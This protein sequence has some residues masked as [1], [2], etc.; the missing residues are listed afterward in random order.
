MDVK[1][2]ENTISENLLPNGSINNSSDQSFN[3]T[4]FR[5]KFD[6]SYTQNISPTSTIKFTL[7]GNTANSNN[8]NTSST[9]NRRSDSTLINNGE[10]S[11]NNNGD[12]KGFNISG[13]WNKKL[14]VKGRAISVSVNESVNE[15]DNGGFLMSTNRFYDTMNHLDSVADVDQKKTSNLRQSILNTSA[16]YR[17]P[18]SKFFSTVLSYGYSILNSSSER[19]SF[20]RSASGI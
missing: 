16:T 11:L 18:L 13:L 10:R 1:G 17:E 14:N 19:L 2:I 6:A 9:S 8:F 20:N 3:K 15:S 5:Q 4:I 12:Q 7:S